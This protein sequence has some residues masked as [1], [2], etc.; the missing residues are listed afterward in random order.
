MRTQQA[1]PILAVLLI[2]AGLLTAGIIVSFNVSIETDTRIKAKVDIRKNQEPNAADNTER[3]TEPPAT[4]P[5][6]P[7]LPEASPNEVVE[8][9][10][11]DS[12]FVAN[13]T[14]RW[15]AEKSG[16]SYF[17]SEI[18]KEV[19]IFDND[20]NHRSRSLGKGRRFRNLITIQCYS[21]L[22]EVNG[23]LKLRL[24]EDGKSM[25]GRFTALDDPTKEGEIRFLRS[26][27]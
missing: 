12:E 15:I 20:S 11:E 13:I 27:P 1:I 7:P 2:I 8:K 14:D 4:Q 26:T 24:S 5:S 22:D 21:P 10:V 9:D 3:R 16:Q 18:N 6:V 23:T 25:T 19:E 17:M